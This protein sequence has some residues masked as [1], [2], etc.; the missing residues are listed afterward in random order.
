M[1][2]VVPI[3]D[4]N[5]LLALALR[6][7]DVRAVADFRRARRAGAADAVPAELVDG[8]LAGESPVRIWREHRGLNVQALAL[9]A[10]VSAPYVSRIESNKRQPTVAA[11]KRIASAL[12]VDLD[13]LA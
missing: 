4:Y 6:A 13:D 11:L 2:A 10:E 3:D 7:G 9:A 12:A 5:R 8:L 1:F